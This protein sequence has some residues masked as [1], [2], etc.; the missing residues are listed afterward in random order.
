MQLNTLNTG[1]FKFK[2]FL[3]IIILSFN[4]LG[5]TIC[6]TS[7]AVLFLQTFVSN[8]RRFSLQTRNCRV[9]CS[10]CFHCI[11]WEKEWVYF[12][13]KVITEVLSFLLPFYCNYWLSF[14]QN[15]LLHFY[16]YKLKYVAYM[17]KK[18][19]KCCA[20]LTRGRFVKTL[21][22]LLQAHAPLDTIFFIN[23]DDISRK[24]LAFLLTTIGYTP[25]FDTIRV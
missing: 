22:S 24:N 17:S 15:Y 7:N 13:L 6:W 9:H 8:T 5:G 3:N 11:R 25:M 23:T 12:I 16:K 20:W 1:V 10:Y 2:E 21:C 14:Q 18:K 19:F 4:Q